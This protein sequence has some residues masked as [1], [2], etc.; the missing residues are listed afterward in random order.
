MVYDIGAGTVDVTINK[1]Y[2]NE[3]QTLS[4][5]QISISRFSDIAG[6]RFDELF[7]ENYLCNIIRRD[8]PDISK[9]DLKSIMPVLINIAEENKG[10]S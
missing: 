2:L 8:Y 9:S 3:F 1:V 7:A 5:E 4:T 10:K 6:D